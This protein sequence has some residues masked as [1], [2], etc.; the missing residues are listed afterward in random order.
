MS[1]QSAALW[2]RPASGSA[3]LEGRTVR[4]LRS[5]HCAR[6]RPNALH[7]EA[8]SE[9]DLGMRTPFEP[10]AVWESNYFLVCPGVDQ[11]SRRPGR[12]A[13]KGPPCGAV[14]K[15][16]GPDFLLL[17]SNSSSSSSSSA[18]PDLQPLPEDVGLRRPQPRLLP[19]RGQPQSER[20]RRP[21]HPERQA[22]RHGG[23]DCL[24]PDVIGR[25][26][27]RQGA[28]A[29]R[30]RNP[31]TTSTT[32]HNQKCGGRG[33]FSSKFGPSNGVTLRHLT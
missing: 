33:H 18:I 17:L 22:G 25:E 3:C 4:S 27:P 21:A 20:V 14:S 24:R 11:W 7:V 10:T 13:R 30:R 16:G 1:E 8:H 26:R 23:E 31:T 19:E 6:H 28:C 29:E 5:W 2:L 32:H 9:C 12:T 15:P